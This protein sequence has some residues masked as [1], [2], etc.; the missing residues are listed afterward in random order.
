[1]HKVA[2]LDSPGLLIALT[3]MSFSH[4]R[5]LDENPKQGG[6]PSPLSRTGGIA[7]IHLRFVYKFNH[8]LY[9]IHPSHQFLVHW[10]KHINNALNILWPKRLK[11]LKGVSTKKETIERGENKQG[12]KEEGS[13]A[14][15]A[16]EASWPFLVLL[17]GAA[18]FRV[19][20]N[21]QRFGSCLKLEVQ[22]NGTC[23]YCDLRRYIFF[24]RYRKIQ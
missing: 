24:Y 10:H 9:K 6:F 19:S 8:L 22:D 14:A 23:F 16:G 17:S 15:S 21:E 3:S 11:I 1:M 2:F 5:Q 18:Y 12:W 7:G 20:S 4:C 13:W